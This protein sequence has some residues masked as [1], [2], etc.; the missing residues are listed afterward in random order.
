MHSHSLW[1]LGAVNGASGRKP[2]AARIAV[3]CW[4]H[5]ADFVRVL[6]LAERSQSSV[7]HVCS[8]TFPLLR[9]ILV[10]PTDMPRSSGPKTSRWGNP[11]LA[12]WSV[13][14]ATR[15]LTSAVG[16]RRSRER[17]GPQCAP[18]LLHVP[19]VGAAGCVR[20]VQR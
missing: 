2:P 18:K 3:M 13:S 16:P 11:E 4:S 17:G 12:G 8:A 7:E 14:P 20:E 1:S 10:D 9:F 19:S 5:H 6:N 15:L